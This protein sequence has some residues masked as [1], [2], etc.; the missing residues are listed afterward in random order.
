[1]QNE[2]VLPEATLCFLCRGDEVLLARKTRNIGA[3]CFNGYGG[4]LEEDETVEEATIRELFEECK[5]KSDSQD[6][7]KIAIV[8]FH[9]TKADG[10]TFVCKCHVYHLRKWEGEPEA[11]EEMIDPTWFKVAELPLKEMMLADSDWVPITLGG[12]K[13][14]ADAYYGPFQKELLSPTTI[15][16]VASF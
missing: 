11:T 9:N 4:S 5:I 3:G 1:M 7:E 6:L 15:Q 14:I 2:K 8:Y 16:R 12:E 13:I 10:T